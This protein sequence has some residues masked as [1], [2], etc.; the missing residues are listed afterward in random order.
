VAVSWGIL[1]T[2]RI[3]ELVLEGV[4]GSDRV[5]IAGVASRDLP[6]AEAYAREHGIE[7]AYGSY[8]ELL[9][10]PGI[11]AV[12]V[13]LPN[14][15]HVEWSIRALQ[16]GKHVLCEKPLTRSAAEAERAYGVAEREGRLLMEAFMWRH[17]PQVARLQGLIA[18]GAIGPVALV[19]AVHSFTAD[20]PRDIRLLTDLDG[21]SLMDVGCYCVHA[22][23]LLAGEPER[24]YGE[25][26]TNE[27]GLDVRFAGTTRS[28]GG[29]VCQFESGLDLPE[30]AELEVVGPEGSLHV[31][32]PWHGFSPGIELRRGGSVEQV[33]VARAHSYGLEV[34]NLSAAVRGEA[35]PL[36]GRDDAV[37]Q[38]RTLEALYASAAAGAPVTL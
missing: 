33:P 29:A 5:R 4:R 31:S 26:V 17:H 1:S 12:Y 11:E 28:A 37:A 36:L 8:D 25:A 22:A 14:A 13:S 30:R 24:V 9:A 34:E 15:M 2:A 21:G 6:R 18:E 23:R 19:R 27:Q 10:D 7:Q 32:D 38:A 3:N 16:A 35:E 20:D